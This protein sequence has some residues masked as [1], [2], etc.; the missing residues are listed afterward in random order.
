MK[1]AA[2]SRSTDLIETPSSFA[3]SAR[4]RNARHGIIRRY[5]QRQMMPQKML[6]EVA[7]EA[8]GDRHEVR[9]DDRRRRSVPFASGSRCRQADRDR[10]LLRTSGGRCACRAGHG[11]S[12]GGARLHVPQKLIAKYRKISLGNDEQP[13]L[14]LRPL[15]LVQPP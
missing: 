5:R 6:V 9:V 14:A 3:T 1:W 13:A 15:Q 2:R 12:I 11:L 7:A 10:D 8:C 4:V